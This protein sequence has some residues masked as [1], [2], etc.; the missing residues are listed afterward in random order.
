MKNFIKQLVKKI[1][2]LFM[3]LSPKY[4]TALK[5]AVAVV[6]AI[7]TA[8][9]HPIADVITGLTPTVLDDKLIAWLRIHLPEFLKQFKL[10]EAVA[11]LTDP[12]EIIIKVSEILQGLNPAD[13]NGERLK[14]A[15]ALAIEITDDGRLDWADAVKI[16]QALKDKSM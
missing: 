11:E 3:G 12:Q 10:F 6:D 8:I 16:I 9:D 5:V 15:V 4:K 7:Y 2:A 13:K 1:K 14:I